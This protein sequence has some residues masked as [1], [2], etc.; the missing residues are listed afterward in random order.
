MLSPPTP[1]KHDDFVAVIDD[2]DL[3]D[4]INMTMITNITGLD[5]NG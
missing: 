3:V 4:R 1:G 2:G 5:S